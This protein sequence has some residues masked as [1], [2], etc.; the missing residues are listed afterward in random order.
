MKD[1]IPE[2]QRVLHGYPI[3]KEA[4]DNGRVMIRPQK[5]SISS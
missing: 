2:K 3:V 4:V 5:L 1:L